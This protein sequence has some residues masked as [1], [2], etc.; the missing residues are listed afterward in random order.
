[1]VDAINDKLNGMQESLDDAYMEYVKKEFLLKLDYHNKIADTLKTR[2]TLLRE[3][4]SQGEMNEYYSQ[5]FIN[6]DIVQDFLPLNNK[7]GY[8]SSF[9]KSLRAEYLEGERMHVFLE[10]YENDYVKNSVLE[11][12]IYLTDKDPEGT[13][14]E[15]KNEPRPCIL[16]DFFQAEE[17]CYDSFDIIYEFYVNLVAY[18]RLED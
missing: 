18:N 5:A 8:D 16:F 17:D 6:F 7:D 13:K 9:I 4:L 3:S 15:W 1:M 11:K 12:T 2:D 10:M 14:I